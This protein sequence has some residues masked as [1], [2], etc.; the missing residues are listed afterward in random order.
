MQK[1][2]KKNKV[3]NEFSRS[4]CVK[5]ATL[6]AGSGAG[7]RHFH[8]RTTTNRTRRDVPFVSNCY[9]DGNSLLAMIKY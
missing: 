9:G 8:T 1:C 5:M 7:I 3:G 4:T 2:K 6:I